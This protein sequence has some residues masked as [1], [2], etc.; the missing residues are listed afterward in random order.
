MKTVTNIAI[1]SIT[2]NPLNPRKHFD[3][4]AI[5]ELVKIAEIE[6]DQLNKA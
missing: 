4:K 3:P 2:P 5:E 6:L 1:T